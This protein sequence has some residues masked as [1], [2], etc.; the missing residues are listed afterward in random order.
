MK[1]GAIGAVLVAL[2]INTQ[3]I[4]AQEPPRHA[5]GDTAGRAMMM[6]TMQQR[7]QTMD[8]MN[9]RL[10]TLLRQMNRASGNEKVTAMARVINE[11]VTQ[12]RAMQAHMH[13]MMQSHGKKPGGELMMKTEPESTRARMGKP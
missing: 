9:A 11:L 6:Q 5:R 1:T 3:A 12:R 7:M 13:Q 8:S 10:D 4:V 2:C